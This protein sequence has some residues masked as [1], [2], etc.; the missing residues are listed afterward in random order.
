MDWYIEYFIQVPSV[1][2]LVIVPV[3]LTIYGMIHEREGIEEALEW[4]AR[5]H[6]TDVLW[7]SRTRPGGF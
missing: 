4:D 6:A 1:L 2:A 7:G 5:T 3:P